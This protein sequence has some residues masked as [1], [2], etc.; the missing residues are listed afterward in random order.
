M[1]TG[2][3]SGGGG[4]GKRRDLKLTTDLNLSAEVKNEW[5]Y[6]SISWRGQGQLYL[7][8]RSSGLS[9][10]A[11]VVPKHVQSNAVITASNYAIRRL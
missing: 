9:S 11:K 5:S 6:T 2:V 7:L 10:A 8:C 1:G 3:V 4:G